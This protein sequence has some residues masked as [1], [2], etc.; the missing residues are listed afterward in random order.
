MHQGVLDYRGNI[1][2]PEPASSQPDVQLAVK[3]G[4]RMIAVAKR[5][6][7]VGWQ[8]VGQSESDELDRFRRV[9]VREVTA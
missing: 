1:G 4:Q 5:I 6:R 9:E 7:Y 3:A 2:P 8:T